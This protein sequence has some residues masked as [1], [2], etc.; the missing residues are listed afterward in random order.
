LSPRIR[1]APQFPHLHSTVGLSASSTGGA[2]G[3]ASMTSGA[4]TTLRVFF[5]EASITATLNIISG[6]CQFN[7]SAPA[8]RSR[9]NYRHPRTA[10]ELRRPDGPLRLSSATRSPTVMAAREITAEPD[11]LASAQAT[12]SSFAH[13]FHPSSSETAPWPP[14]ASPRAQQ[15]GCQ[16]V[17]STQRRA[18]TGRT[19]Q[20]PGSRG[21]RRCGRSTTRR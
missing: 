9:F 4:G 8:M 3:T 13:A 21:V 6:N 7:F 1:T 12:S 10:D 11:S 20:H 14:L 18:V 16:A 5:K 19:G 2:L 15:C 17:P